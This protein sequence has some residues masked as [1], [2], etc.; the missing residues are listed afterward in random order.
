MYPETLYS[1]QVAKDVL[2]FDIYPDGRS[3]FEVYEDDGETRAYERGEW[4]RQLVKVDAPAANA[5]GDVKVEICGVTGSGFKGQVRCRAYELWLHTGAKPCQVLVDGD[6]VLPISAEGDAARAIYANSPQCWFYDADDKGGTVK[7][8]LHRRCT[9]KAVQVVVNAPPGMRA[10]A[11]RPYPEAPKELLAKAREKAKVQ[12]MLVAKMNAADL[13]QNVGDEYTIELDGTWKRVSGSVVCHQNTDERARVTFRI[14]TDSGK[15]IFE[16]VGQKGKD[17]PQICEVN[18]P[19]DA[20]T[21][22]F[23]FVQEGDFAAGGFWKNLK[24]VK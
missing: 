13:Y 23:S 18:I 8:K 5:T 12:T 2:T 10:D 1:S 6:E 19:S 17:A 14:T 20:K 22:T 11:Y 16:R 4:T 24:L 21:L 9:K 7:V 3:E 15:V